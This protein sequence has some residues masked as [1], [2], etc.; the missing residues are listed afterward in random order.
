[1]TIDKLLQCS[2]AELAAMTD[3]E[4]D[5][6]FRPMYTITRPELAPKP[7]SSSKQRKLTATKDPKKLM[8]M[9]M[10]KGMGIDLEDM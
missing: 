5:A 7:D 9:A 10:L 1:M 8:A 6:H 2:A 4:L 3:A